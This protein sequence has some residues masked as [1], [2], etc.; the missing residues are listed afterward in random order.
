VASIH[1]QYWG[2]KVGAPWAVGRQKA[3]AA[4]IEWDKENKCGTFLAS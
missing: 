3:D 1:R 2:A 4:G